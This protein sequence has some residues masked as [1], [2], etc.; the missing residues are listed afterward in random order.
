MKSRKNVVF[1]SGSAV[2]LAVLGIAAVVMIRSIARTARIRGELDRKLIQLQ[3]FYKKD[4]FPSPGNVSNQQAAVQ[5]L[6]AEL[7][8]LLVA[9]GRG[10]TKPEDHTP[11]GFANLL[12]DMRNRLLAMAEKNQTATP[13]RHFAF[14]FDRYFGPGSSL[15]APEDVPRLCQQL[16]A[17][18]AVCT[19]LFDEKISELL[20]IEREEF[21]TARAAGTRAPTA[22][23]KAM[24]GTVAAKAGVVEKDAL[25]AKLHF[26]VEFKAR[27]KALTGVLNRLARQKLFVVVTGLTMSKEAP[28]VRP[29]NSVVETAVAPQ[30]EEAGPFDPVR[31]REQAAALLAQLAAMTP[32]DRTISGLGC[33]NLMRV[34]LELDVYH[35][36]TSQEKP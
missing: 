18:D 17:L 13:G 19:V 27:E 22:R 25:F 33:E 4:P 9:A 20:A 29:A 16:A 30:D 23:L 21:E 34:V 31:A 3:I 26:V 10:Q 24:T 6:T 35:F 15:P 11:P 7:D 14:G 2:F 8:A 5:V 36:R 1:L 32:E 28:D 12:G